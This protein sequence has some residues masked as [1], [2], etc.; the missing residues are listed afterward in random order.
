MASG[1]ASLRGVGSCLYEPEASPWGLQAG[2]R[3]G[4]LTARREGR[5][6]APEGAKEKT[7]RTR[8]IHSKAF[9]PKLTPGSSADSW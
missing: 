5:A 8:D 3:L 6:Y 1:P 7:S 2:F 4:E 9:T